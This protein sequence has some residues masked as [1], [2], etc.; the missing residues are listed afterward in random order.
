MEQLNGLIFGSGMVGRWKRMVSV[1]ENWS[2]Y[3][4]EIQ[5]S[6]FSRQHSL[7]KSSEEK[8][9]A[10]IFISNDGTVS[11]SYV[12]WIERGRNRGQQLVCNKFDYKLKSDGWV[13]YFTTTVTV[14]TSI[15]NILS[16]Y[17][18]KIMKFLWGKYKKS[19]CV[20]NSYCHSK[21]SVFP[22]K[23]NS[24]RSNILRLH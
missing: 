7:T 1:T 19:N 17:F 22:L 12:Y 4:H 18:Q 10:I 2:P 20:R 13:F 15:R 16:A 23:V 5:I 21:Y 6:N 3:S 8:R 14:F 11:K 24:Y 9:T